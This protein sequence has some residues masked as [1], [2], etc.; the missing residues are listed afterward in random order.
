M[1][2]TKEEVFDADM[3]ELLLKHDGITMD[4]KNSLRKYKKRRA[5]ANHVALS[6]DYGKGVRD[7]QK[8]RLYVQPWLGL[9]SVPSDVRAAL[10]A[11]YYDEIDMENSQPVLLHQ[12]A[13]KEGVEHKAL[14][15]FIL[16]RKEVLEQLQTKNN[17]TRDEAKQLC[18]RVFYGALADE[19]PLFPAM[20]K[21]LETLSR[22]VINNHPEF[23]VVAK[24]SK[25]AKQ[26]DPNLHCNHEGSVLAHYAQ[27]VET[28]ILLVIDEFLKTKGYSVDVLQHDG[29]MVRKKGTESIPMSVLEEAQD[30]VFEKTGF[31]ITLTIKALKHSFQFVSSQDNAIVPQH[32]LITDSWAAEKFVSMV[33]D[34]L[35]RVETELYI[36]NQDGVWETGEFALRQLIEEYEDRLTWKQYNPMGMLV[37]HIYGADTAHINKLIIQTRVKAKEGELPIQF[38]FP[39]AD[40]HDHPLEVI[41][42]FTD[43]LRLVSGNNPVL[44]SYLLKWVAHIV[45]KPLDLP[46]VGIVLSGNKGVG[47]D[48]LF[49]FLMEYVLGEYSATN[50]DNNKQFFEK[51]DTG[52]KGKLLIKL[53]EANRKLCMENKDT[54]KSMVTSQKSTFNAKNEKP[55]TVPNKCRFV[56]T[57]NKGNPLDFAEG[58]RRYVILP[59]SS[60]MKGNDDYWTETRNLLFNAE[61]GRTIGD[62]LLGVDL[63]GFQIR[64]LPINAYQNEVVE[65][66][67]SSEKRFFDMWDGQ[68]LS[69]GDLFDTYRRYCQEN[70]LPYAPNSI[71]FGQRL[72]PFLRDNILVK[73]RKTKGIVYCK[74]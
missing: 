15:E 10:G 30:D 53:E 13:E 5:N 33:G 39:L 17:M 68:E 7:L 59:C 27:H 37:P 4:V 25:E 24:K 28:S 56:F 14:G 11:K 72:L 55:I 58:E 52:R 51:H 42:R 31:R 67:E 45:Q 48:T 38:A 22:A 46:G 20:R 71:S 21:E 1:A 36:L 34:R 3:L 43:L 19:H 29:G 44:Q 60:E 23:E 69:S 54:L 41:T 12:I 70:D 18:F 9:S 50:Y 64:I 6:Y 26:R 66:E 49:D 73:H 74:P 65:A 61:A 57:T 62:F 47:K 32:I 63:T 35:R 8:G 16:E 2:I 40:T